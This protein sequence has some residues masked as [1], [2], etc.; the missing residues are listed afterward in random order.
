MELLTPW[1]VIINRNKKKLKSYTIIVMVNYTTNLLNLTKVR[2]KQKTQDGRTD[3][4]RDS[5]WT[6]KPW[7]CGDLA[8]LAQGIY[9]A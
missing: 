1:K 9:D 4:E 8:N 2:F 6:Y 5:P 3:R 7:T